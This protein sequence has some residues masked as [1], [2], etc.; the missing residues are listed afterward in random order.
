MTHAPGDMD[1]AAATTNGQDASFW[2]SHTTIALVPM[3]AAL[4]RSVAMT[5]LLLTLAGGAILLA[6]AWV[7][8][9]GWLADPAADVL[10]AAAVIAFYIGTALMLEGAFQ[11]PVLPTGKMRPHP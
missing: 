5:L 9:T 3:L 6:I 2:R 10:V 4:A 11:R 8:P 1:A 7:T